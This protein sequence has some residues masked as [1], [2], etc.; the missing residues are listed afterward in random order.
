MKIKEYFK[1]LPQR[2]SA[3]FLALLSSTFLLS[4][5]SWLLIILI[6][7]SFR[8]T[9]FSEY[10]GLVSKAFP[11]GICDPIFLFPAS[12]YLFVYIFFFYILI[13]IS[14]KKW[15]TIVSILF[16]LIFV[17]KFS[18]ENKDIMENTGFGDFAIFYLLPMTILEIF[19]SIGI[20]LILLLLELIPKFRVPQSPVSQSSIFK[21]YIQF[22]YWLYFVII[23]VI[24]AII[25][26]IM[27]LRI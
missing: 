22:F 10:L 25:Y 20:Y 7:R 24:L 12:C 11:Y 6:D 13:I 14:K 8:V 2:W 17:S 26:Y 23:L 15:C 21:K 3:V 1:N 9:S 4:F 19:I 16:I 18:I 27:F 5:I